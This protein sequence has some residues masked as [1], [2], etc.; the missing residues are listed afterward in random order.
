MHAAHD[1]VHQIYVRAFGTRY[2]IRTAYEFVLPLAEFVVESRAHLSTE[3]M[4]SAIRARIA[5]A[6]RVSD[7][8]AWLVFA[9]D[10]GLDLLAEVEAAHRVTTFGEIVV[11][12][13]ALYHERIVRACAEW[14]RH[15]AAYEAAT[16]SDAVVVTASHEE[17]YDRLMAQGA[18]PLPEGEKPSRRTRRAPEAKRP[19]AAKARAQRAPKAHALRTGPDGQT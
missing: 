15:V 8:C 3:D 18:Y 14:M 6:S 4:V 19:R 5:T 2:T 7:Q 13:R 16:P 10:V 1:A 9:G 17:G 11:A 12:A